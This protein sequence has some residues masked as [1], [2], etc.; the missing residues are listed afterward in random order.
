M[1]TQATALAM[2]PAQDIDRARTFYHDVLGLRVVRIEQDGMTV[3]IEAGNGSR[4]ALVSRPSGTLADHT[5]LEFAVDDIASEVPCLRSRG[6]V[7]A[8][9]DMPGLKTVNGIA[10]VLGVKAAW[11]ND[12]EGNIVTL[13]QIEL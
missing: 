7:F 11:F 3:V 6:V 4:L 8:E 2:L 9:Y 13:R 12:T 10:E 5:V 1:L